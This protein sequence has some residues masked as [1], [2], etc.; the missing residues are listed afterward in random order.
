MKKAYLVHTMQTL[1]AN[2]LKKTCL[3]AAYCQVQIRSQP[4]HTFYLLPYSRIDLLS[5]VFHVGP[6]S[7]RFVSWK[8]VCALPSTA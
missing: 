7:S 1:F 2:L 3:H 4:P 8:P 5:D 6:P